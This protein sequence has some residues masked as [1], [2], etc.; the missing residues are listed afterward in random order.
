MAS[1]NGSTS[2]CGT[3]RLLRYTVGFEPAVR[4]SVVVSPSAS[5]ASSAINALV[6]GLSIAKG[7]TTCNMPSRARALSAERRA[8]WRTF[9]LLSAR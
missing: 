9:L 5:L 4:I 1:V 2:M 8:S 6:L 3:L 7:S